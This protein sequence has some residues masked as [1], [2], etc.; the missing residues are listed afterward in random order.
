MGVGISS[1]AIVVMIVVLLCYCFMARK[2]AEKQAS[3]IVMNVAVGDSA[4]APPPTYHHFNS[5]KP[6]ERINQYLEPL[7]SSSFETTRL[8]NQQAPALTTFSK[9]HDE[10]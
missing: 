6:Q 2:S 4:S 5:P 9:N 7:S 10:K 8:P 3:K 1:A